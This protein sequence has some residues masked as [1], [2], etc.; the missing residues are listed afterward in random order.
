MSKSVDVAGKFMAM[1]CCGVFCQKS[2]RG[3]AV[4]SVTTL[5]LIY[6]WLGGTAVDFRSQLQYPISC[7]AAAA[8]L[9]QRL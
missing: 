8:T 6:G 4:L 1:Q 9:A 7:S 5:T 3:R 2:L